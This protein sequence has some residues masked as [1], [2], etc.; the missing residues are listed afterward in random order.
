MP[1]KISGKGQRLLRDKKQMRGVLG[2]A[3]LL[4]GESCKGLSPKQEPRQSPAVI[5][6]QED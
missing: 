3:R 5:Q 2:L 6:T 4:Y 1:F